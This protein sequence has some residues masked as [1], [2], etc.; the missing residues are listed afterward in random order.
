MRLLITRPRAQADTLVAELRAGGVDAA[1]LPLIDIAPAADA[2]A[3]RRAWD[4]LPGCALAMFVSANA[5]WHFMQ[6]RP[7]PAAW[8]AGVLAGATGPGT[9]AALRAAGVPPAL[10]VEPA[11]D[12]FDSEALWQ[13]LRDRDWAGRQVLVVRGEHGRDWLAAQFGAAGATVQFVTAYARRPRVLDAAAR[14]L[15]EAALAQPRTHLWVLSSSEAVGHLA[16]LA[17][18]ADW[19]RA[20]AVAPHERIVGALQRLGFG[21]VRRQAVDAAALSAVLHEGPPIQSG[22]P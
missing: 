1:A 7:A 11:G 2:S 13:R 4:L 9:A 6:A 15:L 12:V 10:L 5:V 3:V 20:A 16:R 19:S 14:A 8:P 21:Q 17:P 22:T 18:Q